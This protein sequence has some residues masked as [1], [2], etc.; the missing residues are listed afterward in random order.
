MKLFLALL[1]MFLIT[2]TNDVSNDV[3]AEEKLLDFN[4]ED[5]NGNK[6]RLSDY[7]GKFVYID[8]WATWC[9]PCLAQH[10][11]LENVVA[12]CAEKDIVFI[13][14]SLDRIEAKELWK[15]KIADKKMGIQLFEGQNGQSEF[16]Q[17]LKV[18]YI[19]RFVLINPEGKIIMDDAP[20]PSSPKLKRIFKKLG[21]L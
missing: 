12:A 3:F 20:A 9:G 21:V 1:S 2:S 5:N 13:S 15:N 6:I 17:A 11:F 16:V 18:A 10:P 7:K 14:I 8:L 19:P 4:Y